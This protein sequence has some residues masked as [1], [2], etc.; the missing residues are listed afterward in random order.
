MPAKKFINHPDSIVSEL[1]QGFALAHPKQVKLAA[2]N[3]VVRASEKAKDKVAV[4]TLGGSGHEP[5]LSGFVGEGMLDISVPGEVFAAPGPP[6]VIEA[7]RTANRPAGVLLVVLNHAGDVMSANVAMQM[8]K[9]EGLNVK[10]V[11]THED[12]SAPSRQEPKGRRGLSGCLFVIKVAGAAAEKGYSLEK[13]L[14]V[15][16]RMERNMATLAVAVSSASHPAT[17]QVIAEVPDGRMNIGMGQHG[18]AGQG[19]MDLATADK[20]A[21]VMLDMLLKDLDVKRGER[22]LVMINGVGSTTLMEQYIILRR[23][24]QVLAERGIEMARTLVGE[25]LTVQEMGGFQMV[26]ARM[27]DEL[28]E[29]WD[30]PCDCPA[31]TVK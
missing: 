19:E 14:E 2:N 3:L 11:L 20:T 21:E 6:R 26:I 17:G 15:A 23:V 4:V 5:A 31:L 22:L 9:K 10:Q 18:E 1:L 13:C 12:I 24:G 30:A 28:L 29:L 27:D 25:F 7:I 16:E 8:A